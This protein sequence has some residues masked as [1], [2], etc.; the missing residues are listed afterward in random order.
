[1]CAGAALRL[2]I[3]SSLCLRCSAH[4]H[5]PIAGARSQQ[6][7]DSLHLLFE[8]VQGQANGEELPVTSG[9][10]PEWLDGIKFNNGFGQFEGGPADKR[11]SINHLAD[12]MA[13]MTKIRISNGTVRLWNKIQQTKYWQKAH[14]G[15]PAYRTFNGTT[16][17]MDLATKMRMYADSTAN[18]DNLNV[19]A[20]QLNVN[21]PNRI[22]GNSDMKGF[23]E[24][25]E[26]MSYVGWL[27]FEEQNE[28]LIHQFDLVTGTHIGNTLG[29]KNIY[30]YNYLIAGEGLKNLLAV[31]RIDM[32]QP[33]N[34]P[35]SKLTREWLSTVSLPS[36]THLSYMHTISNTPNY[37]VFIGSV[38]QYNLPKVLES[39]CM[40]HAMEYHSEQKNQIWV[41]EK[42]SGRFTK[43]F[44]APPFWFYHFVNVYE[45]GNNVIMDFNEV[46]Y[47]HIETAFSN[48]NLRNDAP[49]EFQEKPTMRLAVDVTAA[50]GTTFTP[51]VIGPSYDLSTVHPNL[52]GYKYRWAWGL[53][54]SGKSLWYDTII[55]HDVV[56]KKV[57]STWYRK[58]H[59]PGELNAIAKP[60]ATAED[61]VVLLSVVLGGDYGTSYL[62]VL[63]G[64]DLSPIAEAKTPYPL[65]F[66]SHGC[67]QPAGNK[68]NCIGSTTADPF[69][70]PAVFPS[71]E[72]DIVV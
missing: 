66:G 4:V 13:M 27:E 46:D 72:E 64:K 9:A 40:L 61:D 32:T 7:R 53:G 22:F 56:N 35:G 70:K 2:L 6:Y 30:G 62:L 19:A 38:F 60:G 21:A 49:W 68:Q 10:L 48:E 33:D 69:G 36:L 57:T 31:W 47:R 24:A 16:P 51:S 65:P 18:N 42:A 20:I 71:S 29:D 17:P 14:K 45:E 67:W 1:M 11:F 55:K 34:G 12:V 5:P 15:V 54:W 44:N 37:I 43:T 59:Y 3:V 50:D 41:F 25:D 39:V 52:H 26:N 8:T 23:N 58:D 63:D 28:P